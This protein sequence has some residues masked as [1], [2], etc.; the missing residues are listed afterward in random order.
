MTTASA[1]EC[2]TACNTD[3][4]CAK[5]DYNPASKDCQKFAVTTAV[6]DDAGYSYGTKFDCYYL[7]VEGINLNRYNP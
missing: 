6:Q 5:W 3:D 1:T 2:A 4:N 7:H